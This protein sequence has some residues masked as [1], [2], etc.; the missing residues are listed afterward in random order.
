MP[1]IFAVLLPISLFI[2]F[3]ASAIGFTAWPLVVPVLYV[4]FGFDL[5]LTLFISLLV[6]CGNALIITLFAVKNKRI[7]IKKGLIYAAIVCP[8]VFL[9]IYI[10]TIFIPGNREFFRGAAGFLIILLGIFFIFRGI[11]GTGARTGN[12]F[13][14]DKILPAALQERFIG[15]LPVFVYPGVAFMALQTGVFGIGGGMGYALILIICLSFPTLEATGTAM[16]ITFCSTLCALF[17]IYM[18]VPGGLIADEKT[19][20]LIIFSAVMSITGA[21]CGTKIAYSLP[22]NRINILVGAVII[23]AGVVATI[24]KYILL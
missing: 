8:V 6:D 3:A 23:I 7:D 19:I 21:V 18:Q 12:N 22:E 9:G 17:G 15:I 4:I 16:L 11:K 20:C 5:Y 24:Q 13:I 10:G 14:L 2:G 1:T